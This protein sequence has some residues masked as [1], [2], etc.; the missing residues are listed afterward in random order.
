MGSAMYDLKNILLFFTLLPFICPYEVNAVEIPLLAKNK[1][2]IQLLTIDITARNVSSAQPPIVSSIDDNFPVSITFDVKSNSILHIEG[3]SKTMHDRI[4][5]HS[6]SPKINRKEFRRQSGVSEEVTGLAFDW[7]TNKVYIGVEKT[8][9]VR[10]LGKIE[11]CSMNELLSANSSTTT[12]KESPICG[13]LMHKELDSLHSL[14]LDPI[15]GYMYWLNRIHRRIERAWMNGEHHDRHPFH[16]A[17][18]N[19]NQIALTSGLTLDSNRRALFFIRTYTSAIT[20]SGTSSSNSA[21][22]SSEVVMCKLYDRTSCSVLVSK[23]EAFDLDVFGNYLIWTTISAGNNR[24]SR[25]SIG[26]QMCQINTCSND[27]IFSIAN[28][29]LV[30][31]IR[32]FDSSKQ[33]QRLNPNPCGE[34]NGKCSHLC[35]LIPGAP[36]RCIWWLILHI[37]GNPDYI[38]QSIIVTSRAST[39]TDGDYVEGEL[40]KGNG[41]QKDARAIKRCLLNGSGYEEV[42]TENLSSE[43]NEIVVDWLGRNLVWIMDGRIE[44]MKLSDSAPSIKKTLVSSALYQPRG[45]SVDYLNGRIY[46]SNFYANQLKI[47]SML[48]DGSDRKV[49]L[50]LPKS[51]WLS[52]IELDVAEDCIYWTDTAKFTINKA[53]LSDGH[54]MGV[55]ARDL[56]TPYSITKIGSTIFCNSL[57][58]RSLTAIPLPNTKDKADAFLFKNLTTPFEIAESEIY[59]QMSLKAVHSPGSNLLNFDTFL[60]ALDNGGCQHICVQLGSTIR[61]CLCSVGFELQ[62]DLRTCKIPD[63]FLIFFSANIADDLIRASTSFSNTNLEPMHLPNISDSLNALAVDSSQGFV[64]WSGEDSPEIEDAAMGYIARANFN[65]AGVEVVFQSNNL[66]QICGLC[67]DDAQTG[68][69]F[70]CNGWLKRIEVISPNGRL[71]RTLIW[72]QKDLNNPKFLVINRSKQTLFFAN[73]IG[74]SADIMRASMYGEEKRADKVVEKAGKI[75]SLALDPNSNRLFWS[76]MQEVFSLDVGESS[77]FSPTAVTFHNNLLYI[78]NGESIEMVGVDGHISSIHSNISGPIYNLVIAHRLSDY[79]DYSKDTCDNHSPT[80]SHPRGKYP[81]KKLGQLEQCICQPSSPS[82]TKSC[83][84]S[85]QHHFSEYLQKCVPPSNYVLLA[86][87]NKFIRYLVQINKESREFDYGAEPFSILPLEN[88]G[89]VIEGSLAVD[90]LSAQKYIYWLSSS[91]DGLQSGLQLKRA[92]GLTPDKAKVIPF[93]LNCTDLLDIALDVEGRQL[94]V[95][96]SHSKQQSSH[97]NQNIYCYIHVWRIKSDDD[98]TYIGQIIG[99]ARKSEATNMIAYPKQLVVFSSINALFY[100]DHNRQLDSPTI[101]QCQL[102]GQHCSVLVPTGF[103]FQ[104]SSIILTKSAH[105][106][107]SKNP[108][109]NRLLYTTTTGLWSRRIEELQDSKDPKIPD[110]QHHLIVDFNR[111]TIS[112]IFSIQ[113]SSED[114]LSICIATTLDQNH[115][116]SV[117]QMENAVRDA[118]RYVDQLVQAQWI[119]SM[120][121]IL[122]GEVSAAAAVLLSEDMLVN[123]PISLLSNSKEEAFLSRGHVHPL[124]KHHRKESI[125]AAHTGCLYTKCSHICRPRAERA[126]KKLGKLVMLSDDSY[127]D[128]EEQE[129]YDKKTTGAYWN[130]K[131]ESTF[132]CLCPLGFSM[133]DENAFQCEPNIHCAAWEFACQDDCADESD[134]TSFMCKFPTSPFQQAIPSKEIFHKGSMPNI[135]KDWTKTWVCDDGRTVIQKYLLCDGNFDCADH[136]DELYCRCHNPR[137]YFDCTA[138]EHD[139]KIGKS[140]AAYTGNGADCILR[141]MLCDGKEHCR[142]GTDERAQLCKFLPPSSPVSLTR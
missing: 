46:F 42:V 113:G 20:T 132:E 86:V 2:S 128:E 18:Q 99:G 142:Y 55:V 57:G 87:K 23:V 134:E 80:S 100:M 3:W 4:Q 60:C 56:K 35:L 98:L 79:S 75:T 16:E 137:D 28:T 84:C 6:Q 117:L 121:D 25:S 59:G 89:L 52:A 109:I 116:T 74:Q 91:G 44:L 83:L 90:W 107:K 43:L 30:E 94:F 73:F 131:L 29:S 114:D 135:L 104:H 136:S 15:D 120:M 92:S 32:V 12:A 11:V 127:Y 76:T 115:K 140:N 24:N 62:E 40:Y 13:V 102:N 54:R 129:T 39:E 37:L 45:L 96:C 88:V 130:A 81:S 10:N 31:S 125:S 141:A 53:R 17:A 77:S 93:E 103:S 111:A 14:V 65:G 27:Q 26:V 21:H 85:D 66:R 61:K 34:N 72:N 5:I 108:Q 78:A 9:N 95:S 64:Y 48:M 110:I 126:R 51:S 58:G 19:S 123:H 69:I 41:I 139:P 122:G 71:R 33:P 50:L 8:A 124:R 70:V 105:F 82:I 101:I 133:A 97:S 47:E 118:P 22:P 36:W 63:E 1:H 119:G 138:W 68:N 49:L 112:S 67:V 38:P 106:S 7:I